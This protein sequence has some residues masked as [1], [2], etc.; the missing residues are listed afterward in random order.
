MQFFRFVSIVV[1]VLL[2]LT[3]AGAVLVV[4]FGSNDS[5]SSLEA[6]FS[7]TGGIQT[8][9]DRANGLS[10]FYPSTWK[11]EYLPFDMVRFQTPDEHAAMIA[12]VK[13][14][15]KEKLRTLQEYTW[16]NLSEIVESAEHDGFTFVLEESI[17]VKLSGRDGHRISTVME[18]DEQIIRA[19][20]LWAVVGDR[21]YSF[22][23]SAALTEYD[24]AVQSFEDVI[25]SVTIQ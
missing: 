14:M 18:K 23:F 13:K 15:Q 3:S 12:Q 2:A 5:R 20:Q 10:F 19:I 6:L 17:P 16:E 1:L 22:S 4:L 8:F 21:V 11:K 24:S 7:D 9:R 25:Q